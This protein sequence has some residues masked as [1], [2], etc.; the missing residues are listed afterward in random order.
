MPLECYP[1]YFSLKRTQ[2]E[3]S[4]VT[5]NQDMSRIAGLIYHWFGCLARNH[6]TQATIKKFG[7]I[8]HIDLF[9]G[10]EKEG[11]KEEE[12]RKHKM[13]KARIHQSPNEK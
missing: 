9:Q 6:S 2:I 1:T 7:R 13:Q 12:T 4:L 3:F 10:E 11:Q 8:S 5:H